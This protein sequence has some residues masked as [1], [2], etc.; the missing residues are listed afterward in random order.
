MLR[1]TDIPFAASNPFLYEI[2]G[3]PPAPGD[4]EFSTRRGLHEGETLDEHEVADGEEPTEEEEKEEKDELME[5]DRTAD[6]FALNDD[7]EDC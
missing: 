1:P 3:F 2:A 4:K 7:I 6:L 5:I